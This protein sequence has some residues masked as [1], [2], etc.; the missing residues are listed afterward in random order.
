MKVPMSVQN[1]ILAK[2]DDIGE[3]VASPASGRHFC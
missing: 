1:S 2:D 3:T